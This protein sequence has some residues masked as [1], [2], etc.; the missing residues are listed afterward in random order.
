MVVETE[1]LVLDVEVVVLIEMVLDEVVL[2]ELVE[3]VEVVGTVVV[4]VVDV[5]DVVVDVVV[6]VVVVPPVS[7][8]LPSRA[9]S[10]IM[11]RDRS[12]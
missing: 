9:I 4:V 3:L 1:V 7:I 8:H 5:V 10:E 6:V 12:R 11:N 2:V